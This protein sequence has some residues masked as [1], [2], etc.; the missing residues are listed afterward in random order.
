MV[1]FFTGYIYAALIIAIVLLFFMKLMINFHISKKAIKAKLTS[2][3]I[4]HYTKHIDVHS[5]EVGINSLVKK[6]YVLTFETEKGE[7]IELNLDADKCDKIP[8]NVWGKLSYK[9]N[10][11]LKFKCKGFCITNF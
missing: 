6:E 9:E 5:E 3:I 8:L 2:K 1:I 4:K 7:K 10:V 11:L